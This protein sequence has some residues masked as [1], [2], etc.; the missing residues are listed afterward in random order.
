ML[1]PKDWSGDYDENLPKI[2]EGVKHSF[3]NKDD[4]YLMLLVGAT[5]SG[6]S[7]LM[8]W[9]YHLLSGVDACVDFICLS[10]QDL[11]LSLKKAAAFNGK[12]FVAY[13]EA[14]IDK[15]GSLTKWNRALIDIYMSIRGLNIF[16]VWCNPS[17]DM[18]DKFFIYERVKCLL[19]ITGKGNARRFYYLFTRE[20]LFEIFRKSGTLRIDVLM[21][22]RKKYARSVGYFREYKGDLKKD[23]LAKKSSRMTLKV[24]EFFDEFGDG[25]GD[26]IPSPELRKRLD[27]SRPALDNY[28]AELFKRGVLVD[29][30]NFRKALTGRKRYKEDAIE[31]FKDLII[32]KQKNSYKFHV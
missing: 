1:K 6:K 21:K 28:E 24:D 14:N 9:I 11:T 3:L 19:L 4:D 18:L 30:E 10:R 17:V 29:G 5:G 32:E 16:H 31:L 15:R 20:A 22:A 13:D 25:G 23:Y 12:R 26:W 8:L 2:V 7:N 27:I